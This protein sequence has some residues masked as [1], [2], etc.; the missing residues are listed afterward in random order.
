MQWGMCNT[1][2]SGRISLGTTSG[3]GAPDF[4]LARP[5]ELALFALAVAQALFLLAMFAEGYWIMQPDGSG[6]DADFV[7]VWAAGR[8]TRD[9]QPAA[10]YDWTLHKV[11]EEAAVGRTLGVYYPWFYPPPF[12][13]VASLL[14]SLPYALAFGAW[15]AL[16]LPAYALTIRAIIGQRVGLLFACAFP[17]VVANA[18]VGQNGYVTAALIGGALQLMERRPALAGALIGLLTYKPHFGLLFPLALAA[19][20][21]WRVFGAAAAVTVLIA[22]LSYATLGAAP[23][24]AFLRSMPVLSQVA[25]S[26]GMGGFCKMHSAFGL[27]R[28]FGGGERL[29]W[30]LQGTVTAAS[31]LCVCALWYSRAP[32]DMKAAGLATAAL[33]VTP[34]LFMYDLVVLAVPM[35]F[36]VRAGTR[37]G[38]LLGEVAGLAAATLMILM[39]LVVTAPFGLAATLIIAALVARRVRVTWMA[40]PA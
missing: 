37:G 33:L 26:E 16:T 5:V 17:A 20:G 27:V 18:M 8:L 4:R 15:V 23:W 24:E 2:R 13:L 9:G 30:A 29:A 14:A 11:A 1:D 6:T 31:V 22:A 38:F 25:L 10:A 21:R 36:L 28:C 35:A 39:F 19:G 12:L 32:F 3:H 34:Y 7:N 40:V